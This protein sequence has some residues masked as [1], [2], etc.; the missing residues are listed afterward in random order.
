MKQ[1]L[2]KKLILYFSLVLMTV[3]LVIAV[4]Y[5]LLFA[6]LTLNL[7]REDMMQRGEIMAETL[8]AYFEEK[9]STGEISHAQGQGVGMGYGAFLRFTKQLALDDIWITDKEAQILLIGNAEHHQEEQNATP[10]PANAKKIVKQAFTGK[11]VTDEEASMWSAQTVT[12]GIPI[13]NKAGEVQAAILMHSNIADLH[14]SEQEARG[15]LFICIIVGLLIGVALSAYFARRFIQPIHKMRL[16]TNE[17]VAENYGQAYLYKE[18]DEL[19]SLAASLNILSVRLAEAKQA[20]ENKEQ[21]QQNF[22][23]Q[24]SHELK[25][26]VTVMRASLETLNDGLAEPAEMPEYHHTL[27]EEAVLLDRLVQDILELSRLENFEF[28]IDKQPMNLV[29]CANDAARSLREKAKEKQQYIQVSAPE[30]L[31]QINGDYTRLRQMLTILLE[32]ACKFGS[33]ASMI[34][35]TIQQHSGVLNL[36]VHNEGSFIPETDYQTIFQRFHKDSDSSGYGLGLAIAKEI[37][38][39]HGFTLTVSSDLISG[40]TFMVT[41]KENKKALT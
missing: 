9:T 1:T 31:P 15:L 6:R 29:D 11:I 37:C 39:R 10:L 34:V 27:L 4:F 19:G 36:C 35:L 8:T 22:L 30:S 38:R 24:V 12:V 2:T 3:G 5:T 13:K 23:S 17:L 33:P 40:T 7:H 32:N 14:K 41:I 25:T 28:S 16:F 21:A 20:Q 26:P 18:K